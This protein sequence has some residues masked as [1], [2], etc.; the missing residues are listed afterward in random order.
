MSQATAVHHAHH[1]SGIRRLLELPGVYALFKELLGSD[2]SRRRFV[3]E[4]IPAF[5][6]AHVLDIGCGTGWVFEHL[7]RPVHYVGYDLNGKYI[8]G[9]KQ[10]F[11]DEARFFCAD[12]TSDAA[13]RLESGSF[14]IALALGLLHHLTDSEAARLVAS[15][16]DQL[17]PGGLFI[18]FDGVFT[19]SQNPIA[20]LLLRH[21]RGRAV[22]TPE[23]YEA[24]VRPHFSEVRTQIRTDLLR[25]PYTHFFMHCTNA[26]PVV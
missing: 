9:A 5:P 4:F 1:S 17:K 11:G 25:I 24:L 23:G 2:E 22:R 15:V 20:R 19:P 13:P 16:H 6:G 12:I 26:R 21:D 14:D 8:A 10:R 18:T 7:P 3:E